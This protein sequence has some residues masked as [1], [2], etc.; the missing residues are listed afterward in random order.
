MSTL[1]AREIQG[2]SKSA[3]LSLGNGLVVVREGNLACQETGKESHKGLGS[4]ALCYAGK[5]QWCY[6]HVK[7]K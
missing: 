4:A 1:Q 5:K 3:S 7:M 6:S 2:V